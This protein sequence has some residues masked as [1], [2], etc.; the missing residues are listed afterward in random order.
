MIVCLFVCMFISTLFS[1]SKTFHEITGVD[2]KR[3]FVS[4]IAKAL[5]YYTA[6]HIAEETMAAMY[7][8]QIVDFIHR[9]T[10]PETA[11]TYM[12]KMGLMNATCGNMNMN[13]ISGKK[14]KAS[15]RKEMTIEPVLVEELQVFLSI[16]DFRSASQLVQNM[17]ATLPTPCGYINVYKRM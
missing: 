6:T 15:T 13:N 7:N 8:N 2:H 17:D 16:P 4:Q 10:S 1:V 5:L 9:A 3:E 12:T 11:E 14:R